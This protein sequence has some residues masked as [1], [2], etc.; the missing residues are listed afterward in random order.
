MLQRVYLIRHCQAEGQEHNAPLTQ[1]GQ[2][3]AVKLAEFLKEEGIK[4]IYSSPFV[5]AVQTATP[6]STTLEISIH[7]DER[8]QERILSSQNLP[9]WMECLKLTFEDQSLKYHGGETSQDATNRAIHAVQDILESQDRKVAIVTHG[10]LM[11]LM[12]HHFNETY[13]FD[14][15]RS[16]TNPDVFLLTFENEEVKIERLWE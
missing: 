12:L 16:L 15:W 2:Q 4:R 7:T 5:R 10:N 11:S 6:L 9:D 13:G 14:A 3:D 1:K 8:L